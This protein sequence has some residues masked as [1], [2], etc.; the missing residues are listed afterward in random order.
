MANLDHLPAALRS[1]HSRRSWFVLL[2]LV[3]ASAVLLLGASPSRAEEASKAPAAQSD[4]K[5][6]VLE[7]GADLEDFIHGPMNCSRVCLQEV[8]CKVRTLE[9]EAASAEDQRGRA[10]CDANC[11]EDPE[12]LE[13]NREECLGLCQGYRVQEEARYPGFCECFCS[14]W[15]PSEG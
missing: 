12:I 2:G 9:G 4:E 1:L 15:P 14:M 11:A 7:P 8:S 13:Q 5:K 6:Q 3:L 10:F